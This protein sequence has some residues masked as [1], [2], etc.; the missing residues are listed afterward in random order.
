MTVVLGISIGSRTHLASDS[1][2]GDGDYPFSIDR[3]GDPK[4]RALRDG[5]A[6][7]FCGESTAVPLYRELFDQALR[8]TDHAWIRDSF[9]LVAQK[10]AAAADVDL[11]IEDTGFLLALPGRLYQ[12]TSTMVPYLV[13][14]GEATAIG[15]GRDLALGAFDALPRDWGVQRRMAKAMQVAE[16]RCPYVSE[17]FHFVTV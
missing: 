11:P 9:P 2:L 16:H 5:A 12:V 3:I 10:L 17:P 14:R 8:R 1:Y 7:A 4:I 13:P 6:L 15:C